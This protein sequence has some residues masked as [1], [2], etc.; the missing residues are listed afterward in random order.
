MLLSQVLGLFN[1]QKLL[2]D[3][4]RNSGRAFLGLV[5]HE[6]GEIRTSRCPCSLPG[7]VGPL[8]GVKVG[9]GPAVGPE[10]WLGWPARPVGGAVCG[11]HAPSSGSWHPTSGSWLFG[12]F[13]S[14]CS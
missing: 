10:V 9:V 12:L 3:Q 5:L 6:G 2:R 11:V 7:G 8:G 1:Q 14:C 13:V 4:T